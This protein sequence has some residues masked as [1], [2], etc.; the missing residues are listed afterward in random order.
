MKLDNLKLPA[1][2]GEE[3]H[4]SKKWLYS[5]RMWR[6]EG[7]TK[8]NISASDFSDWISKTFNEYYNDKPKHIT[9]K[10]MKKLIANQ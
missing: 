4:Y 2:V 6:E 8:Y 9:F 5:E 10:E 3:L 7:P 1:P